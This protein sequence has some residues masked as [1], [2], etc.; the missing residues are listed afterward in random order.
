MACSMRRLNCFS[1]ESVTAAGIAFAVTLM[2][3]L[4]HLCKCSLQQYYEKSHTFQLV[5]DEFLL[6][7]INSNV[8]HHVA[9]NT[10]ANYRMPSFG[11]KSVTRA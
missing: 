9:Q 11:S 10:I 5:V 6:I 4:V 2:L 1:E 8:G 7:C 3:M